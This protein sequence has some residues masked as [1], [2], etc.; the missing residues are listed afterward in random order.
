MPR[1][2][3]NPV[4]TRYWESQP[5]FSA[6]GKTILFVSNRPGGEGSMDIWQTTMSEEGVFTDP[7]NIGPPVNTLKDETSPF[8]HPDGITLYFASTGHQGMGGEDIFYATLQQDGKWTQPVNMGYPINTIANEFNLIVNAKGDKAFFS[9]NKK[10]GFGKL[11]LYWFE[12]PQSLRPLPVTY[13]KGKIVDNK[14]ET[15]LEA[16]FEVIDLK[17]NKVVITSSSDPVTGEFLVCIPTNSS[18]ALNAVKEHYLFYSENFEIA[19][20]Y[21]EI[22]PY[23][24]DVALKRIELG[25]SIILK[26]VFFDT[27]KADLKP[28]SETE[29]NRL[30][31]LMQQNPRMKV[32]ISGH[33][34]NIGNKEHNAT[35]SNNRARSVFD[36]LVHQGIAAERMTYKGYG[37]DKPVASNDTEEGRALNRRTE[38]T[39]I[40]F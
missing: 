20:T 8:L 5:T 39:I 25:E 12:L 40:G 27:D 21:S 32:E 9:S 37:F 3:G 16:L 28:A 11:D 23:E 33:T 36:Y 10:G 35:L 26:N 22:L 13:F 31:L 2:F 1:N 34:D 6:D 7:V 30:T 29:L 15:P 18:Y 38:F 19:G 14:D 24:K 4:S 17:T